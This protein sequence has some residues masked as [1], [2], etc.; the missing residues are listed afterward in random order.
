VFIWYA[1]V[2][3]AIGGLMW[4]GQFLGA[5]MGSN[6]LMTVDPSILRYLVLVLCGVM[7]VGQFL[8]A[9]MGSNKLMTVDPSIL[10][11]LV[12]VLCGVMLVSLYWR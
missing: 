12:L 5:R 11:Y 2:I 10:R 9:R 3:W 6:K 7:W 1:K 8:G 4:V